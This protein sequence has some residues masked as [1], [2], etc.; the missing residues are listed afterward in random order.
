MI[1]E[2]SSWES[3]WRSE[4]LRLAQNLQPPCP[5]LIEFSVGLTVA[6]QTKQRLS[7]GLFAPGYSTKGST[8]A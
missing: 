4:V 2:A 3:F 5:D 8:P 1:L 7:H 6:S